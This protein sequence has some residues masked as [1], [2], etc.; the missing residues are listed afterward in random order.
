MF[1]HHDGMSGFGY[2]WT[3]SH[4]LLFWALFVAAALVI[5]PPLSDLRVRQPERRAERLLAERFARGDIGEDEYR[6]RLDALR[7]A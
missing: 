2:L 1:W 4:G 6:R 5:W 3:L 7:H